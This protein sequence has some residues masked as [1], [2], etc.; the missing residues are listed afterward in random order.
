[1]SLY[2]KLKENRKTRR[3]MNDDDMTVSDFNLE[4]LS[5]IQPRGGVNYKNDFYVRKG[6]GYETCITIYETPTDVEDFWLG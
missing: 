4:L 6:T 1:M 5:K 3:S 2:D